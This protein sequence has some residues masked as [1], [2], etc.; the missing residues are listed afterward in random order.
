MNLQLPPANP[1]DIFE[2]LMSDE[3][4][5]HR[6]RHSQTRIRLKQAYPISLMLIHHT[7]MIFDKFNLYHIRS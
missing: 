6:Q 2:P 5:P 1:V 7:D 4:I 3:L